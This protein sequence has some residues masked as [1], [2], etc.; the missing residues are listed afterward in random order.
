MSV[1]AISGSITPATGQAAATPPAPAP[2]ET[3]APKQAPVQ[4]G[5]DTVKLSGAALARSLKQQGQTVAQII[6]SM[7][8]DAK[9]VDSYLGVSTTATAT[10]APAPK[11]PSPAEEAKEPAAEKAKE[12]IAGKG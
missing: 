5:H 3:A 6:Q 1:S 12:A 7:H 11:A 9:T 4:H 10:A 8:L 2:A